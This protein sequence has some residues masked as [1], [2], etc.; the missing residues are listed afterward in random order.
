MSFPSTCSLCAGA[1][2][3][4]PARGGGPGVDPG[5]PVVGGSAGG[6]PGGR[7]L[8][9]TGVTRPTRSGRRGPGG[10]PGA[11]AR[12]PA[13]AGPSPPRPGSCGRGRQRAA[14]P[15]CPRPASR[16]QR[17][18]CSG[19]GTGAVPGD[20]AGR[21]MRRWAT[22]ARIAAAKAARS[23]SRGALPVRGC[24]LW[25]RGALAPEPDVPQGPPVRADD[26]PEAARPRADGVAPPWCLGRRYRIVHPAHGACPLCPLVRSAVVPCGPGGPGGPSGRRARRHRPAVL[27]RAPAPLLLTPRRPPATRGIGRPSG[28]PRPLCSPACRRGSA[29]RR[30]AP[31]P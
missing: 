1:A 11:G 29:R 24:G 23:R 20:G 6:P 5:G 12:P 26:P 16:R 15:R 27:L 9:R 4:A 30:P 13:R 2:G 7:G 14:S 21:R 19:V 28:R 22:R 10:R 8:R 18:S 3:V 31:R 25:P 17:T